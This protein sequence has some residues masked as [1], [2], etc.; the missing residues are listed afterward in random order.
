MRRFSYIGFHKAGGDATP[1]PSATTA[2][3]CHLDGT[4]AATTASAEGTWGAA[5]DVASQASLAV[6]QKK[7]G[8]T[9]LTFGA[10]SNSY[11]R[12]S[13]CACNY[14]TGAFCVDCWVYLTSAPIDATNILG[15]YSASYKSLTLRF[16][17]NAGT[18]RFRILGN[19]VDAYSSDATSLTL[20]KWHHLALSRNAS[21][22][23]SLW[24]T[25]VDGS[26][27]KLMDQVSMGDP[28]AGDSSLWLGTTGTGYAFEGYLD[29]IRIC[30]GSD[31]GFDPTTATITPPT[32][33]YKI[34]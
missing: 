32:S 23:A 18:T 6:A 11:F 22:N 14:G 33:P 4:D 13:N 26:S 10:S 34:V 12:F 3:L 24:L 27:Q 7:F 20:N 25:P 31:G 19:G 17:D 15:R 21:G 29:E 5:F 2:F 28:G 8:D 30:I 1:T 9:S 16:D